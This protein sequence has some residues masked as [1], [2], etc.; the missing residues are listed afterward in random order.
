MKI[1]LIIP[2]LLGYKELNKKCIDSFNETF[3][4]D[5]LE[6]ILIEKDQSFAKN[7]NE[8]LKKS[9]GE[10]LLISNN[11]VTA[12]PGWSE[13]LITSVTTRHPGFFAFSPNPHCG[14]MFAM[15]RAVFEEVGYL[16]DNL[17]NSYEDYDLFIRG[18]LKGYTRL[19]AD[20]HYAVHVGGHTL[21]EVWGH[22]DEQRPARLQ[23]CH[24]NRNYMIV[25]W[26]DVVIDEVPYISWILFGID[27]MKAWA[28]AHGVKASSEV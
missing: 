5:S 4:G 3:K 19:L 21:N 1:S 27:K 7:V 17:I 2:S 16:D 20:K 28:E 10:I 24:A 26:P 25:K 22:N 23:Q 6:V 9:S 14:W 13:Y 18:A 15:T 12:L 8:G 11:D